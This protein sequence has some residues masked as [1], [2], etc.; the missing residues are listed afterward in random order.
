MIASRSFLK[1]EKGS[2]IQIYQATLSTGDSLELKS[3]Y[4]HDGTRTSQGITRRVRNTGLGATLR[5]SV[6]PAQLRKDGLDVYEY[7]DTLQAL[8]G[9]RVTLTWYGLE[10]PTFVLKS[11]QFSLECDG[12]SGVSGL[13]VSLTLQEGYVAKKT[14]FTAVGVL[15]KGGK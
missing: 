8:V 11:A 3:R 6:A 12:C 4:T 14:V 13:S 15:D 9:K 1:P 5:I 10:L 7:V 2:Q